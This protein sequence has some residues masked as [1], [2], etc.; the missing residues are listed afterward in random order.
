MSIAVS[1]SS[2]KPGGQS[3]SKKAIF[4]WLCAAVFYLYQFVIRVSP[5]VIAKDM[6]TDLA[7]DG[8]ALGAVI[9]LFYYG[10]SSMQI[11][12]GIL[13]DRLGVRF[14]LAFCCLL[15]AGGSFMFATSENL[16][17]LSLGRL[18]MGVGAAFGFLSNVKV[19]SLWFPPTR[20]PLVIG[21][22]MLLGT[23]GAMAAGKPFAMLV[24]V[25]G[26]QE[27][28]FVVTVAGIALAIVTFF[29][30]EDKDIQ[31]SAT[32][33]EPFDIK[34]VYKNL[35]EILKRPMTWL[36]GLYGFLMYLPLAGFADLWGTSFIQTAYGLDRT[37]ASLY[38]SFLYFGVGLGSP[39]FSFVLGYFK[40]YK[41][42][43]G[44]AAFLTIVFFAV[45]VYVPM[46]SLTI[47]SVVLFLCGAA[48]GGQFLAFS[49]V[50]AINRPEVTATAS[51]VHNM[52]CMISGVVAQPL[53]GAVLDRFVDPAC[54]IDERVYTPQAFEAGLAVI[55]GGLIL[56][57]VSVLVMK[58]VRYSKH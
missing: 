18:L 11:P 36:L 44:L 27:S 40:N 53:I 15:C 23:T 9:S 51:G 56:S 25:M 16:T 41:I 48:A 42:T 30:I 55:L 37:S 49:A 52:L 28:M 47:L 10:Y 14:P 22:T 32:T 38:V 58:P 50:T 7:I 43:L 54:P 29:V 13:L 6:M 45:I 34:L 1:S 8:C 12:A 20:M 3:V 5:N 33:K 19:A 39:A 46:P 24:D 21:M 2:Q 31:G 35:F 26:W 57:V 17:L 4:V